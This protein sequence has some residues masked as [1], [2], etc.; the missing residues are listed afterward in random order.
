MKRY[1]HLILFVLI[2]S[3]ASA[4]TGER[5]LPVFLT[6]FIYPFVILAFILIAKAVS[7]SAR[8]KIKQE[9]AGVN[10]KDLPFSKLAISGIV[11]TLSPLLPDWFISNLYI[12]GIIILLIIAIRIYKDTGNY[13][14][15]LFSKYALAGLILILTLL[16]RNRISSVLFLTGIIVSIIALIKITGNP[17]AMRGEKEVAVVLMLVAALFLFYITFF[18]IVLV[19]GVSYA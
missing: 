11:L 4:D 6:V 7:E 18:A 1:V 14:D 16:F 9:R 2:P 8:N 10:Y 12:A 3:A 15:H 17:T 5:W 13:M 19:M